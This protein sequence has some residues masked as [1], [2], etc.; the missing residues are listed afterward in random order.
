VE[1]ALISGILEGN[2]LAFRRMVEQ[3]KDLVM[4]ACFGYVHNRQDAEDLAQEVFVEA[5]RSIKG[6][7]GDSRLSTWL[8]RIATTKSMDLLKSRKRQKRGA[9][10][11]SAS[12]DEVNAQRHVDRET[13]QDIIEQKERLEALHGAMDQLPEKQRIAFT[14]SQYDGMSSKEVADVMELKANAVD[15][16]LFRARANMRS[17]LTEYYQREMVD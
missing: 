5:F 12:L 17:L 6:F 11:Q 14:L 16:L 3:Y 8:Y 4:S 9:F 1:A 13:P 2:E 7:R 15:A 10:F